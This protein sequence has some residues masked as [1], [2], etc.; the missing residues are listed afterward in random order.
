MLSLFWSNL[1]SYNAVQKA[2]QKWVCGLPCLLE[3]ESKQNYQQEAICLWVNAKL[4]AIYFVDLSSAENG[5]EEEKDHPQH[6]WGKK[7]KGHFNIRVCTNSPK[8]NKK[9]VIFYKRRECKRKVHSVFI[10]MTKFIAV[11]D[12]GSPS[13]D[14]WRMSERPS[15]KRHKPRKL[16]FLSFLRLKPIIVLDKMG[17]TVIFRLNH[18]SIE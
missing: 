12:P 11:T 15:T 3:R 13:K 10:G 8:I 14:C 4:C 6:L 5:R 16:G 17:K 7:V 18:L 2:C 9:N 1:S